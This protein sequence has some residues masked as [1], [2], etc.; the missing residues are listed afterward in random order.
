MIKTPTVLIL[1]A[2]SSIQCGYPLGRDLVARLCELR[3]THALGTLPEGWTRE[4]AERFLDTLSY[5]DPASIDAFLERHP[6][7][8][9]LGKYLITLK[10]KAC[11]DIKTLFPPSDAGWYRHLFEQLLVNGEPHFEQNRLSIVTFNYDRSLEA[12][13]HTRLKAQFGLSDAEA[14][15]RLGHVPILHVHGILGE[16]PAYPYQSDSSP[17]ELL[18]IS[19]KIQIIHEIADRENDYCNDAFRMGHD[20]ILAAN[21]I[22]ILGFGFHP[23]NV[24]RFNAFT[25]ENMAGKTVK[26]TAPGLTPISSQRLSTYLATVGIPFSGLSTWGCD[27]FFNYDATLE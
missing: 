24:R 2:G 7:D 4:R 11:E 16:L 9:D 12:Y 3:G 27:R 14:T 15:E 22:Y 8:A 23:D 5:S 26:F 6:E 20:L 1:G 13:L 25:P 10:L 17:D 18:A 19:R 21:R